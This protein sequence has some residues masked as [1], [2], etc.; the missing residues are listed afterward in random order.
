MAA[1]GTALSTAGCLG[2]DG[3]RGGPAP[4]TDPPNTRTETPGG[5]PGHGTPDGGT[6]DDVSPGGD[7]FGASIVDL[8]TAPR[9]YALS[10]TGYRTPA[11]AEVAMS[12]AATATTDHPARLVAEL[13]NPMDVEQTFDLTW[14]PP[15]GRR[16]SEQPYQSGQDRWSSEHTYRVELVFAPTADH[17]LVESPP[18]VELAADG[19]WRLANG[20]SPWGPDRVRLSPG[21]TV[22][23]E[24]ALV[25][26][27]DGAGMGRPTGVYEFSRGQDRPVRLV[28][29]NTARPGPEADSRFA[30]ESVPAIPGDA[31]TAWY[32]EAD[33]STPTYVRPSVERAD[34]PAE[35]SFT[36]VNHAREAL[37]CGHW[38]LYKRHEGR[39]FHLGPY[40]RTMECRRVAPGGAKRWELHAFP[41]EGVDCQGAAVY[42]HLGGGRYA[43]VAGYGHEA[44]QSAAMVELTGDPVA[45]V[46]TED[47]SADRDG[48]RV[49]VDSPR[50]TRDGRDPVTVVVSR[51]DGADR[52][53]VAEQVMRRRYRG[54]RNTLPFFESG[55]DEVA[56][57]TDDTVAEQAVGYDRSSTRFRFRGDAYE[58]A[59][60]E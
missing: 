48:A 35:V 34:L 10:G 14:A 20:V 4:T 38:S 23:G 58:V 27:A 57:H 29:W 37:G 55:V 13:H 44:P 56:L 12:F 60:E 22:R 17:D 30:G 39:W 3:P 50:P 24:Y 31:R 21:E 53:V 15:F 49:D 41:G 33:A 59:L 2:S 28:V 11:G 7:V 26:R 32:H 43:A 46:P 36:F 6:D 5:T 47:V 54:L 52:T 1:L 25:G 16:T 51:A 8:E 19:Y 42:G 18:A 40:V 9:T 45:V